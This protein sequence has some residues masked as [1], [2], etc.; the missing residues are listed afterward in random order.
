M[1][2]F[3]ADNPT[4]IWEGP[5]DPKW[6]QIGETTRSDNPEVSTPQVGS[7]GGFGSAQDIK[8]IRDRK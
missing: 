7:L 6:I 2:R 5:S 3:L 8:D 1:T 4:K